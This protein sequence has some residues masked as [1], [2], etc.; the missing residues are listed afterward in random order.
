MYCRS[1]QYPHS[2]SRTEWLPK[3]PLLLRLRDILPL[4]GAFTRAKSILPSL[5]LCQGLS[6]GLLCCSLCCIQ[7]LA[8]DLGSWVNKSCRCRLLSHPVKVHRVPLIPEEINVLLTKATRASLTV[9][10]RDRL[11]CSSELPKGVATPATIILL[12]SQ[13]LLN[14]VVTGATHKAELPLDSHL[15]GTQGRAWFLQRHL[16]WDRAH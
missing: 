1:G 9:M 2:T 10:V 15:V 11:T 14:L 6:L 12:L 4:S 5:F 8:P 13:A 7:R 16:P 3:A